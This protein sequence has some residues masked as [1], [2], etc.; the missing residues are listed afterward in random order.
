MVLVDSSNFQ[1]NVFETI[2]VVRFSLGSGRGQVVPA[3]TNERDFN[4]YRAR[5]HQTTSKN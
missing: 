5:V 1:A 4:I 2:Y 3:E